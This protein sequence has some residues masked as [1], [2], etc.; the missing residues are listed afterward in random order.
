MAVAM[1]NLNCSVSTTEMPSGRA[2]NWVWN[3]KN[4]AVTIP[5]RQTITKIIAACRAIWAGFPPGAAN[6]LSKSRATKIPQATVALRMYPGIF[7]L[8]REKKITTVTAQT[9]QRTSARA[10]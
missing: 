3:D 5:A 6:A 1:C 7:D 8:D 9:M 10:R 2:S 4:A